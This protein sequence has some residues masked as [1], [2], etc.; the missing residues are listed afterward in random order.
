QRGVVLY[1]RHLR[2]DLAQDRAG[3]LSRGSSSVGCLLRQIFPARELKAAFAAIAADNLL[4]GD[5]LVGLDL[6]PD[7]EG[8]GLAEVFQRLLLPQRIVPEIETIAAPKATRTRPASGRASLHAATSSMARSLSG[9]PRPRSK[10]SDPPR[11]RERS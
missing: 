10:T 9:C 5:V 11:A 6:A 4:D 8:D 2:V 7:G 3:V 1:L